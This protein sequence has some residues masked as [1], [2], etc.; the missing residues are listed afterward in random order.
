[1]KANDRHSLT[2]LQIA[3]CGSLVSSK[4]VCQRSYQIRGAQSSID[5]VSA[6]AS[7]CLKRHALSLVK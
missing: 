2:H 7:R 3:G 5:I 1:M 6:E 4:P